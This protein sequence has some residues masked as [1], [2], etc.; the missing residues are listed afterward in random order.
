MEPLRNNYTIVIDLYDIK[1]AIALEIAEVIRA[2]LEAIQ[3]SKQLGSH[4][5]VTAHVKDIR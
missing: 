2:G 4:C 3:E 1:K 5:V